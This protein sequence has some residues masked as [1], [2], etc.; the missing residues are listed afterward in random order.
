MINPGLII[1]IVGGIAALL[2]VAN[3]VSSVA[4]FVEKLTV[5]PEL[6]GKPSVEGG[7]TFAKILNA[8]A[9][10]GLKIPVRLK[11]QNRSSEEMTVSVQSVMGYYGD[12]LIASNTP[13]ENGVK[14]AAN[15]TSTL[16]NIKVQVPIS[17]LRSLIGDAVETII[18]KGDYT[19]ILDK[20]VFKIGIVYNNAFSFDLQLKLNQEG[21][22][23]TSK[24]L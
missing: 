24:V 13:G 17:K 7:N 14:I 18:S 15:S 16:N 9:G 2:L 12:T 6:D 22:Y 4:N 23:D 11:F 19:A 21:N 20:I 5:T 10:S 3:K 8:I 1:G